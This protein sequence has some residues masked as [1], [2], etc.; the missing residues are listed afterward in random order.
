M[1]SY[2]RQSFPGSDKLPNNV[3]KLFHIHA[4]TW[5][6]FKGEFILTGNPPPLTLKTWDFLLSLWPKNVI[7]IISFLMFPCYLT[8]FLMSGILPTNCLIKSL[9]VQFNF[10]ALYSWAIYLFSL[11]FQMTDIKLHLW[12]DVIN[13]L[14]QSA[15]KKRLE[16][17]KASFL[18]LLGE[19][20]LWVENLIYFP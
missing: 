14:F 8:F 3:F 18:F 4:M 7:F 10:K 5:K 12:L 11:L 13:L 17:F 6:H 2:E 15:E 9:V 20:R 19:S 16:T 1:L